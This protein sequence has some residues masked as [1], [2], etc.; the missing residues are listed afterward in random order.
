MNRASTTKVKRNSIEIQVRQR[1]D[2]AKGNTHTHLPVIFYIRGDHKGTSLFWEQEVWVVHPQTL[3][4]AQERWTSKHLTLKPMGTTVQE[5]YRTRGSGKLSQC[6]CSQ[7]HSTP[8]Q[9]KT[10][11]WK[12]LGPQVKRARLST[13]K[14]QLEMQNPSG[15][16]ARYRDTGKSRLQF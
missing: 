8:N 7:T 12:V 10:L 3:D 13:L 2:L 15:V 16:L 5:N 4:P 14:H 6:I 9:C 11:D 1:D